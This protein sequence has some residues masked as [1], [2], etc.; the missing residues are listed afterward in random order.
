[1]SGKFK[2]GDQVTWGRRSDLGVGVVLGVDDLGD[3]SRAAVRFEDYD[4]YKDEV[5]ETRSFAQDYHTPLWTE[6]L[7][8]FKAHNHGID[9]SC[10]E[11]TDPQTGVIRGECMTDKFDFKTGDLVQ[12][13]GRSW[14]KYRLHMEKVRVV[15]RNTLGPMIAN[16]ANDGKTNLRIMDHPELGDFSAKLVEAAKGGKDYYGGRVVLDFLNEI[17]ADFNGGNAIKYISRAGKKNPDTE[18]E[19]AGKA[20]DYVIEFYN[21]IAKRKGQPFMKAVEVGDAG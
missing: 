2:A 21:Q 20:L 11:T 12:L 15:G 16:K 13:T 9:P 19:D 7:P 8:V 6:L 18:L 10:K 1:M 14:S 5:C 4:G 3:G 17:D